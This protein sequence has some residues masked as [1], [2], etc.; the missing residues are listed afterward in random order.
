MSK[1]ERLDM[2]RM[3]MRRDSLLLYD[4]AGIHCGKA[5]LP[6]TKYVR[7]TWQKLHPK[8]WIARFRLWLNPEE[9]RYLWAQYHRWTHSQDR[10]FWADI[11][12][13]AEALE[14]ELEEATHD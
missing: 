11:K 13:R 2:L 10:E 4:N 3:A 9:K 6:S 12:R 14:R 1:Q 8:G 5:A 7:Q